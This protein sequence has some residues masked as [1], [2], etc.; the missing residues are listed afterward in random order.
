MNGYNPE[1]VLIKG[2]Y[3]NNILSDQIEYSCMVDNLK[4]FL[5]LNKIGTKILT[6]KPTLK[7]SYGIPVDEL[8]NLLCLKILEV[9]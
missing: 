7:I 8:E 4:P 2:P 5:G 9:E 6:M 3:S 1:N